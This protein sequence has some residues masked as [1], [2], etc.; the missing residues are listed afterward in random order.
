M[1]DICMEVGVLWDFSSE[2]IVLDYEE[3]LFI[4]LEEVD[5]FA[6]DLGV[7]ELCFC[8][9]YDYLYSNFLFAVFL[10]EIGKEQIYFL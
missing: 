2:E 3:I 5:D 9:F 4:G 10:E 6:L 8:E 1:R 7:G